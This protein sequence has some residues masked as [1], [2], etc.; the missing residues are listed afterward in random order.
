MPVSPTYP[1][2]YVQEVDSGSRTV[3][4]VATSI[5][6]FIGRAPMG[7]ANYP[8]MVYDYGEFQKAFGGRARDLPMTYAVE[9]FFNNGGSQALVVR[10]CAGAPL[11]TKSL[12][13]LKGDDPKYIL[14]TKLTGPVSA[15]V[16]MT[17]EA[18]TKKPGT[19]TLTF[20]LGSATSKLVLARFE[21]IPPESVD[22]TLKRSSVVDVTYGGAPLEPD[23][24]AKLLDAVVKTPAQ[25]KGGSAPTTPTPTFRAGAG[26]NTLLIDTTTPGAWADDL[27]LSLIKRRVTDP[28]TQIATDAFTLVA[29]HPSFQSPYMHDFADWTDLANLDAETGVLKLNTAPKIA[30]GDIGKWIGK[31]IPLTRVPDGAGAAVAMQVYGPL[32]LMASSPGEWGNQIGVSFDKRN[33]TDDVAVKYADYGIDDST[34]F[35]NVNVYYPLKKNQTGAQIGPAETIGPVYLGTIDAPCRIDH[36]LAVESQFLA[37]RAPVAPVSGRDIPLDNTL[38]GLTDPANADRRYGVLFDG[39][40]GVSMSSDIIVGDENFRSGMFA[41]EQADLFNILV[42]PPDPLLTGG[43]D[44]MISIYGQAAPYCARRRAILIADPLDKWS[45]AAKKSQFDRIVP[46]DFAINEIT[47]RRSVFTYFP[48]VKK[49]DP[50]RGN[51]EEVFSASGIIAGIFAGTDVRRGVWKAPAGI[52]AGMNGVTNL[53]H[54]LTDMQNGVLNQVGVNVLRDFPIIGK[55]VWGSRTLAGADV[56]SDDYKYLP[57]R[58]LTNYVEESLYRGSKWAV[59]EPNTESL[60]AQLRLTIGSFMGDLAR[61]GAFYDYFV[62]CDKSTTTQFDIDRGRVNVI[63]GM[64]PVKPAEFIILT[65][66]QLAGQ[67]A[68]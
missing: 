7:P 57:V 2:V 34:D 17:A 3:S 20:R 63:V 35:W 64:A 25:F 8:T 51:R 32:V 42:I 47:S 45:N 4:G 37:A 50:A 16:F 36:K 19:Y 33:I 1:G 6:A 24:M 28:T 61:Q 12:L 26:D 58:R 62:R 18:S 30:K 27:E 66:Q 40:D 31:G 53:E 41:L 9:D 38:V 59:F 49:L 11:G 44:D 10:V 52:E 48:R 13:E 22:M 56:L 68:A 43:D 5:T 67:T 23:A 15:L 55:V 60:W 21:D 54:R 65:I 29:D 14:K 39:E 46:T